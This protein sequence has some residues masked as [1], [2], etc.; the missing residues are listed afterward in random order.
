[1]IACTYF[2][3]MRTIPS[4]L[5]CKHQLLLGE[6]PVW[7]PGWQ[8]FLYVDI[9]GKVIGRIDPVTGIPEERQLPAKPG[10]VI[11]ASV[12]GNLVLAL[13]GEIALFDFAN[14]TLQR[15][16]SI[17]QDL[18]FN[19]CNDA[20]CDP[21]GRLWVGT[22]HTEALAGEGALYCYDGSLKKVLDGRTV[23]NGLGWSPDGRVMYYIDSYEYVVIAYDFDLDT[24]TLTNG[25]IAVTIDQP[26]YVPDGL[27]VDDKGMIWVGIWG[28]GRVNQYDPATGVLIAS[29]LVDA[30]HVTSCAFGGANMDLLLITTAR[31]GL[32]DEQLQAY[33][34]SGSLFM[35]STGSR[36]APISKAQYFKCSKH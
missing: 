29:V 3:T 31:S 8:R 7:H 5:F 22:M 34:L 20:K 36:G 9:E 19:R 11:P 12:A 33:P 4:I 13:Q 17:E 6:G 18:P 32:S 35:A 16:T 15:L 1:M 2:I 21:M 27:T 14:G 25:R 28:G 24:G 10:A 23:S 26:G 30:P